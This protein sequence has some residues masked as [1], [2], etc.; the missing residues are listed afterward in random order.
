MFFIAGIYPKRKEL[1]FYEPIMCN[2]CYN[3]G[4]YEAFMEYNVFSLFFIPIIKFA[5]KIYI[6]TTCCN[7]IYFLN[8]RE[9]GLM[10]EQGAHNISLNKEDLQLIHKGVSYN[11]L[12]CQNCGHEVYDEHKYCPNCGKQL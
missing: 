11:N 12:H 8:N 10:I 3:Y 5:K 9:K 1:D 4:R 2:N 7:N 6:K